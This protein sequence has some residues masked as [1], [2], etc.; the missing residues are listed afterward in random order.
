MKLRRNEIENKSIWIEKGFKLPEFDI[1][2]MIE[3]TKISPEWIHFG[4]GNIFRAFQCSVCQE[5]LN[6]GI[7]KTGIIVAEGYDYEIIDKSFKKFD[8]LVAC[9]T[10]KSDGNLDKT[11]IASV[12]QSLKADTDYKDWEILK[13]I[14]SKKSL[15]MASFTITEKGYNINDNNGEYMADAKNDFKTIPDNAKSYMGK[16]TA[17]CYNR[18]KN[19]KLPLTMVSMD[20]CS[21]NGDKLKSAVISFAEKWV[22]NKIVESDFLNYV[23]N[24]ISYPW[25]MIDKITPRPADNVIEMLNSIGF[26]ETDSVITAKNTYTAPFVNA[27]ECQYLI[28]EDNFK[29]GRLPLEKG[30]IIYTDRQTVDKVEKMKVCTCLNPL[31]TALAIFGCLL[32][33]DRIFDEMND[34]N[35]VEL[36]KRIGYDEGLPVVVDPKIIS[37]KAFIDEVINIRLPNPYMSDTP[38]RIAC[39]TSQKLGIRFGE[40]IKAYCKSKTLNVK[41]LKYIPLVISGWCRYLM[42]IDDKGNN[43][44]LSPDPMIN[45]LKKYIDN[46]SLG[47]NDNITQYI[48][49]ILSDENIFGLNLYDAGIGE[50]TEE[51]FKEFN[52]G[53]NAVRKT[54]EKY[55]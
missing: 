33:Y 50:L 54:L 1:D 31:H 7:M 46:I 48:K 15:K 3:N 53:I 30:G 40:T 44:E 55:C 35:L 29:N 9:I 21:H 13:E 11:I 39:D 5:L 10:L 25:S 27:E 42:G 19:G 49:P 22:E 16:I 20:N 32:C 28:I 47:N 41:E 37:P 2:D 17:L 24:D 14:F 43:F 34:K 52:S 8:N 45:N 6:K 51:F 36:I 38:Q 18:F 12:A 26:E 4:A 23:N